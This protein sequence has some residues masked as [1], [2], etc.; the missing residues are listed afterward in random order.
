M[1]IPEEI[2]ALIFSYLSLRE[3]HIASQVCRRWAE[4]VSFP[5]VWHYTEISCNSGNE[6]D[7]N[8]C[9]SCQFQRKI[10]YLKILCNQSSEVNRKNVIKV[11]NNMAN[12]QI[13]LLSLSIICTGENPYFYSGQDLLQSIGSLLKARTRQNT[14]LQLR[15]VDFRGMPFTL[16]DCI[17]Q[18]LTN[19]CPHLES[20][21]IN[22]RTFV[23][24]VTAGT[25]IEALKLCP[26]LSTLGLFHAS[27]TE[28]V[29]TEL[30]RIERSP[31]KLL[32]LYCERMDKYIPTISSEMWKAVAKRH[33]SLAVDIELDSSVPVKKVPHILQPGIPIVNIQLNTY[34]NMV[35]QV[36]FISQNYCSTLKKLVLQTTSSDDL[37]RALLDLACCCLCLEEI[38]CYC[39]VSAEVLNAFPLH[40]PRLRQYTLK[41]SREPHPWLPAILK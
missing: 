19:R 21:F 31:L 35:Q 7:Y 34:T 8:I 2:L 24:K 36:N 27:L 25:I 5:A 3:R 9:A 1:K 15:H 6:D 10:K 28:A 32:Q 12:S 16:D 33:P 41:T 40:C 29:F 18:T 14:C 13:E 30:L 38:H 17:V 11:L 39:M 4:A 20:L 23:C 26:K 22:N 37:D